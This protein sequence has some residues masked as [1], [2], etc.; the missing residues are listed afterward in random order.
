MLYL[1]LI[2]LVQ[3]RMNSISGVKDVLPEQRL[4]NLFDA[5]GVR[6]SRQAFLDLLHRFLNEKSKTN[7]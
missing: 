1:V 7:C 3:F 6:R 5:G 4:R 2:H